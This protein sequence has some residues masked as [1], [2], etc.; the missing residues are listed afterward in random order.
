[1]TNRYIPWQDALHAIPEGTLKSAQHRGT[2][3]IVKLEGKKYLDIHS[4]SERL[5]QRI[6]IAQKDTIK[7]LILSKIVPDSQAQTYYLSYRYN[8]KSLPI[9]Y[10]MKYAQV[11]AW[12]NY[13]K[14]IKPKDIKSLGIS[15][16]EFWNKIIELIKEEKIDLP[17]SLRRLKDKIKI[18]QQKGYDALIDWRFGNRLAAKV[19]DELAESLL[20]E[21]LSHPNQ[22]DDVLIAHLY[23]KECSRLGYKPITHATVGNWRRKHEALIIARRNGWSAFDEKYR[24]QVLGRRP[25]APLL[26]VE[27]D[28]NVLDLYFA[29]DNGHYNRFT[30]IVVIDSYNDY[31]LGYA[32][33]DRLSTDL[34]RAAY[35][36]A[37]RHIKE[38]TG[39]Y[40]LPWQIKADN[41]AKTE[42]FPFYQSIATFI[43]SPVGSKKRGYIEQF[44]RSAHWKRCLKAGANNY[45]GH[46]VVARTRGVN[47][48]VLASQKMNYPS[49]TMAF[50]QIEQFFA[51]L[52]QLPDSHGLS[53]QQQWLQ[54][55][56]SL[57]EQQ[58]RPITEEQYLLLF[59]IEKKEQVRISNM[60]IRTQINLQE[61][62]Y[63]VPSSLRL[64]AIGKQVKLKYDPA[65]LSRVLVV[66]EDIR[67]VAPLAQRVAKALKDYQPGERAYLN[68][69]LQEKRNQVK[70]VQDMAQKRQQVLK[71]K[72]LDA[73]SII[74]A[75]LL[76]KQIRHEAE[77][78]YLQATLKLNNPEANEDDGENFDPV[79]ELA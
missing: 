42:L 60:G 11:A 48:E 75:G 19:K 70:Y 64:Q 77:D 29:G 22:Y 8:G 74:N 9:E 1:M 25:S 45:S 63:E 78:Y 21:L 37:A 38:L 54:A 3:R 28:D 35:A 20:I 67:F 27:H 53:K 59:G 12:L 41:W 17:T 7:E 4:L 23:N 44:F 6:K 66:G 61:Y 26:L 51:R 13:L 69:L 10:V 52:R 34:V 18:Y 79:A 40:Y 68:A 65:D 43:P 24:V 39:G 30:A 16:G 73:E 46:N 2:I 57:P 33:A 72:E 50:D 71:A 31:V 62:Y 32:Y 58:K 49:M 56:Q 76:V 15:R 5:R 47:M 14:T 36:H 55:W